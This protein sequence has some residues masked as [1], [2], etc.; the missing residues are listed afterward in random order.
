MGPNSALQHPIS[1]RTPSIF[2]GKACSY[3]DK[4]DNNFTINIVYEPDV[5][6]LLVRSNEPSAELWEGERG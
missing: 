5:G 3:S 1:F 6:W 2:A 4:S